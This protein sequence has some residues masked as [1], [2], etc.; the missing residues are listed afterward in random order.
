[1]GKFV[2]SRVNKA[3]EH[4]FDREKQ[5][6]EPFFFLSSTFAGLRNTKVLFRQNKLAI[7]HLSRSL[8]LRKLVVEERRGEGRTKKTV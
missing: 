6:G 4:R 3:T 2:S 5:F 1:M 8:W 7:C